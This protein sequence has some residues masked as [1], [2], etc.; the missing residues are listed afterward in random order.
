MCAETVARLTLLHCRVARNL[1]RFVERL[2]FESLVLKFARDV[3]GFVAFR[4]TC[5]GLSIPAA[6][7]RPAAALTRRVTC[8]W[9]YAWAGALPGAAMA[10]NSFMAMD[11]HRGFTEGGWTNSLGQECGSFHCKTAIPE[12]T[13]RD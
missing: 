4:D 6:P 3:M 12:L 8:P 7:W 9:E 1:I 10:K 2:T 11:M 5:F 13:G